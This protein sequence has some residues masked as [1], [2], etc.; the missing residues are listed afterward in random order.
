MANHNFP[1]HHPVEAK[2]ALTERIAALLAVGW[3]VLV[4]LFFYVFPPQGREGAGLD[5]L[6]LTM[7]LVV[8]FLPVVVIWLAAS[9]A[10]GVRVLRH[11][12]SRQYENLAEL[13]RKQLTLQPQASELPAP[14]AAA[15]ETQPAVAANPSELSGF[16][17]RRVVSQVIIPQAAPAKP[18]EQ[19]D[20]P[21]GT[22]S[23]E[24][25]PPLARID[26]IHG[27]NFP[28]DEN[29]EEGFAAL[30]RALRDRN[31]RKLVQASQDVLTLLS[32]EG[33]YMD[34]LPPDPTSADMWREFARGTR[35]LAVDPL[36]GIR[37]RTALALVTGRMREDMVFRDTV[38]HFIRQF[39]Q[40][41]VIFEEYATDADLLELADTRTA[42][43]FMLV[44]RAAGT[45]D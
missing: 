18:D 16:T 27:L 21:F 12:L 7:T 36:G 9:S 33:I 39:D 2:S 3:L 45:F 24:H 19:C 37:D 44:A 35:G 43:A 26:L 28:D 25:D 34:D 6:R 14:D 5:S 32:Q 17:S 15:P 22:A 11:E 13:H 8:V 41:L 23:E 30:R 1:S 42:R 40:I 29:D 38:L 20:L 4:G 10:K 31:A